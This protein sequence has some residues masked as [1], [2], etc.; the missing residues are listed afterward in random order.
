MK[1]S[2][3]SFSM[4]SRDWCSGSSAGSRP[5]GGNRRLREGIMRMP[6]FLSSQTDK[7]MALAR[8]Y[9]RG[10]RHRHRL[11]R[12]RI[13]A[14][15]LAHRGRRPR[16]GGFAL[17]RQDQGTAGADAFPRRFAV[18]A[19]G[20]ILASLGIPGTIQLQLQ[21]GLQL[22]DIFGI[23]G[24]GPVGSRS[25]FHPM[26]LAKAPERRTLANKCNRRR[27]SC[28]ALAGVSQF[29]NVRPGT[30]ANSRVFAVTTVSELA[31]AWPASGIS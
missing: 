24:S 14:L 1:W 12:D 31:R 11:P 23:D 21:R 18:V 19:V 30:R 28:S 10:S 9:P 5:E 20:E 17:L 6:R 4:T 8:R 15:L 2:T 25:G 26:A 3:R 7:V 22:G 16:R 29:S 27:D 13:P